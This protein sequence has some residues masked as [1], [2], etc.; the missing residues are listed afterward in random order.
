MNR[1]VVNRATE[2]MDAAK[3]F[4]GEVLGLAIG[5]DH[6]LC[7]VGASKSSDKLR[8]KGGVLSLK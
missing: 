4:Y 8:G 1:V 7:Q 6:H 3:S 2:Q 5:V